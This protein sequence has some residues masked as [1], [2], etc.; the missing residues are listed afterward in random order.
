MV[1]S[2]GAGGASSTRRA[3]RRRRRRPRTR[4]RDVARLL[5]TGLRL[6]VELVEVVVEVGGGGREDVPAVGVKRR[7]DVERVVARVVAAEAER[8]SVVVVAF[9]ASVRVAADRDEVEAMLAEAVGSGARGGLARRGPGDHFG[10]AV[11]RPAAA[12]AVD[13]AGKRVGDAVAD[14][15]ARHAAANLRA[16]VERDLA[17]AD[18]LER[19]LAPWVIGAAADEREAAQGGAADGHGALEGAG[20]VEHGLEVGAGALRGAGEAVGHVG[21]EGLDGALV[22]AAEL[23]GEADGAGAGADDGAVDGDDG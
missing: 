10:I 6:A 17:G 15:A 3:W 14:E 5:E 21:G 12:A 16:R 1:V 13:V 11:Q 9:V 19:D 4:R 7:V 8:L 23:T 22:D 18:C 20:A 2:G